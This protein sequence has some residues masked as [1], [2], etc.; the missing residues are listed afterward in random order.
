MSPKLTLWLV[1]STNYYPDCKTWW[2][3][4]TQSHKFTKHGILRM[5]DKSV[6][7]WILQGN[8][9]SSSG[10]T[11]LLSL[12]TASLC[13]VS[14]AYSSLLTSFPG[15]TSH[16]Y[17]FSL[18]ISSNLHS[19]ISLYTLHLILYPSLFCIYLQIYH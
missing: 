18:Q 19:M 1:V 13:L 2:K 8:Q 7:F 3:Y 9:K 12:N 11:H 5:V 14:T 4:G 16:F 6:W 15:C 10:C 17:C